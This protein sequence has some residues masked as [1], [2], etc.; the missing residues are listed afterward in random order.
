MMVTLLTLKQE[1]LGSNPSAAP[2]RFG[3][4]LPYTLPPGR[5]D[6]SRVPERDGVRKS[7]APG[8][9]K[10]ILFGKLRLFFLTSP[11]S[12]PCAPSRPRRAPPAPPSA[13]AAPCCGRPPRRRRRRLRPGRAGGAAGGN[14]YSR[15]CMVKKNIDGKTVVLPNTQLSIR[16][17]PPRFKHLSR[18][19]PD[20]V[21]DPLGPQTAPDHELVDV[22]GGLLVRQPERRKKGRSFSKKKSFWHKKTTPSS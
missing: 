4:H 17:N 9:T 10:K 6:V 3:A 13:A 18:L 19:V 15:R 22:Q 14:G 8:M 21:G 11:R 5:K 16:R 7:H 12:R 2:S 1:V 20:S